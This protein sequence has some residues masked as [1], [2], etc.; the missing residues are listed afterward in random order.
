MTFVPTD[1][2]GRPLKYDRVSFTWVTEEEYAERMFWREEAVFQRASN[3]G[4][5]KCPMIISDSLGKDINGLQ[6]QADGKQ[7]DSKSR[8]R[9]HYRDANVT[10]V[11]NEKWKGRFWDGKRRDDPKHDK[12]R[13]DALGRAF[14]RVGIPTT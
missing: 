9:K 8:L 7:Y 6:S 3:Q 13:M 10:E 4:E 2:Q 1:A 11:G 12:A 5:L 14:N